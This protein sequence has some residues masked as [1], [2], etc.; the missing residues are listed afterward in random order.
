MAFV[1]TCDVMPSLHAA[2][3]HVFFRILASLSRCWFGCVF[4][5]ASWLLYNV[6]PIALKEI[7]V[8]HMPIICHLCAS[9]IRR[10]TMFTENEY[11]FQNTG[12]KYPNLK[13]GHTEF[14][15]MHRRHGISISYIAVTPVCS[16]L[17]NGSPVLLKSMF[18]FKLKLMVKCYNSIYKRVLIFFCVYAYALYYHRTIRCKN[19]YLTVMGSYSNKINKL[20]PA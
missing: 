15:I 16:H 3:L 12:L 20:I 11:I 4:S 1:W 19:K 2:T 5:Q 9:D 17:S 10:R 6:S 13:R 14:W 8:D 7:R 18:V